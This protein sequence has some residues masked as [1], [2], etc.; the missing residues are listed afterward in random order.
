MEANLKT[1]LDDDMI[2]FG[3]NILGHVWHIHF[4]KG[5]YILSTP[6][7]VSWYVLILE[8]KQIARDIGLSHLFQNTNK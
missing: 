6:Q 7:Q 3:S 4:E 1:T 5:T 8:G 2:H